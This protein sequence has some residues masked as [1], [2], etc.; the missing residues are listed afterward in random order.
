M[1]FTRVA[2]D[3]RFGRPDNGLAREKDATSNRVED[4]PSSDDRGHLRSITVERPSEKAIFEREFVRTADGAATR[5]ERHGCE[6]SD[7]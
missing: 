1:D 2:R 4:E 5:H 3:R 7:E 6:G